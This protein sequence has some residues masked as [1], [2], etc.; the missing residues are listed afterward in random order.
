[1]LHSPGGAGQN[2]SMNTTANIKIKD[3]SS[4]DWLK[5]FYYLIKEYQQRIK[6]NNLNETNVWKEAIVKGQSRT[7][8]LKLVS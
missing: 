1:M 6:M 2:K 7:Y 8:A 5:E 3:E 4:I